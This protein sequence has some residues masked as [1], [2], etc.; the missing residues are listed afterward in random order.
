MRRSSTLR[1]VSDRA[2]TVL[3]DADCGFC[4]WSVAWIL[5][6][7]PAGSI[8]PRTI[9]S[10]EGQALLEAAGV[11]P[12]DRLRAAHAHRAGDPP[13][14]LRSGGDVAP[15][16]APLLRGRTGRAA[17]LGARALPGPVRRLLYGQVAT[18]RVAIGRLVSQRRRAEADALLAAAGDGPRRDG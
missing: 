16:V 5:R 10:P 17:G 11:P 8:V 15:M 18:N 2:L 14:A 4:R 1:G 9:Q 12:Q 6:H 3:Y 7:V 13:Q